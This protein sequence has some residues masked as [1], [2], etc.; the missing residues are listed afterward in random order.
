MNSS[1]RNQAG[2][3]L[4]ELLVVIAIIG[5]LIALLLPAVQQARE[6][7]RRM[8]CTNH[9]KQIALALH[10]FHDTYGKFPA[11][12]TGGTSSAGW[13]WNAMILPQ[14]EQTN[15]YDVLDPTNRT[16]TQA[17]ADSTGSSPNVLLRDT[18]QAPLDPYQ[19][20]SDTAPDIQSGRTIGH[21]LVDGFAPAVGNYVGGQHSGNGTNFKT[22]KN[23]TGIFYEANKGS[24]FSEITDGTSNTILLGERCWGWTRGPEIYHHNAANQ[25][26]NRN[27]SSNADDFHQNRGSGD[28]TAC[29][30]PGI[31]PFSTR[32][33]TTS[34]SNG[35]FAWN[36]R[37]A[38]SSL[39]PG[40]AN[41][42]RADGSVV[43]VSE[44]VNQT[45]LNRLVNRQDGQVIGE[46]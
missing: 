16:A 20:P 37:A 31:N 42:C 38:F 22:A 7:A 32:T 23:S 39:H 12:H 6:A 17:A 19:C 4:V 41:L 14:M 30:E 43:F 29:S 15:I 18:L 3:T 5:V 26:L 2:F 40:G 1:H 35:D 8:Q 46:Y 25:Y 27:H 24:S 21:R 11:G 44:T 9:E 10:N 36:V 45:I 34:Q 13:S 33:N 28:T